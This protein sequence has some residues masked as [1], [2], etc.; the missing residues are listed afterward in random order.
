VQADDIKSRFRVHDAPTDHPAM[1]CTMPLVSVHD[2]DVRCIGTVF[3]VAPGLAITAAHVVYG[4][5]SARLHDLTCLNLLP[6]SFALN[7]VRR[8]DGSQPGSRFSR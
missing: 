7:G 5:L 2:G 8:K 6:S 1:Q 3:A 4:V